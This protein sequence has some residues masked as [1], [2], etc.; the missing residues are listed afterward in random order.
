MKK[1]VSLS[2]FAMLFVGVY[3][4]STAS[5]QAISYGDFADLP[6]THPYYKVIMTLRDRGLVSGNPDNTV[7]P[8]SQ[9][10]R[11]DVS[12]LVARTSNTYISFGHTG[13]FKDVGDEWFAGAICALVELNH[14]RGYPG[15]IFLPAR[16]MTAGEAAKTL[17]NPLANT[18]YTN[19]QEALEAIKDLTRDVLEAE[20]IDQELILRDDMITRKEVFAWLYALTYVPE[21]EVVIEDT[22]DLEKEVVSQGD[23]VVYLPLDKDEGLQKDLSGYGN[24]SYATETLVHEANC[25]FGGCYRFHGEG[26]YVRIPTSPTVEFQGDFTI[27]TWVK[28]DEGYGIEQDGGIEIVSK[29]GDV[30]KAS[31]TLYTN[32]YGVLG[33]A[34]HDG[35]QT[36]NLQGYDDADRIPV[37]EWAHIVGVRSN[38]QMKIYVNGVL[39]ESFTSSPSVDPMVADV[40]VYIGQ[41]DPSPTLA[42]PGSNNFFGLIDEV[43]MFKRAFS[44]AEVMTEYKT[45]SIVK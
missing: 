6:T 42:S 34:T 16:Q 22:I 24:D 44:D 38:K 35:S 11:A 41:E 8:D 40:D 25:K 15:D 7:G 29:F 3:S 28:A 39:V 12:V 1:F 2:L 31:Y 26:Q 4:M 33:L 5:T 45:G 9:L 10:L 27:S 36:S 21:D 14:L 19:L 37:N 20:G 13:C 43:K 23:M 32:G 30:G 18:S 17:I